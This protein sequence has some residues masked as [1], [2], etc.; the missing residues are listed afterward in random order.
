[1]TDLLTNLVA[2]WPLDESSG[3]RSDVSGNGKTLTDNNTVTSAAGKVGTAAQSAWANSEYLSRAD[4][5]A[6]ELGSGDYTFAGWWKS[7]SSFTQYYGILGKGNSAG[8]RS[9]SLL[10]DLGNSNKISWVYSTD[11]TAFGLLAW[12]AA[13]STSTW[14]FIV[15]RRSGGTLYL[16]VDNGTEVSVAWAPAYYDGT[17]PFTLAGSLWEGVEW[18]EDLYDEWGYWSRSLTADEI[19]YL[20]NGG[21]GRTYPF[22]LVVPDVIVPAYVQAP[23]VLATH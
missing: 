16:S 1:M 5:A 19:T 9:Y 11:G 21:N 15:A 6:F 23:F 13:P 18:G 20:Y 12:S 8:N 14:Y 2:Y 17:H 7:P 22:G 3:S 4:E 10:T